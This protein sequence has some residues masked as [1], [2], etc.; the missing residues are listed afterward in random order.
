RRARSRHSSSTG[1]RGWSN[2]SPRRASPSP[3][4][5]T[6]PWTAASAAACGTP[7]PANGTAPSRAERARPTPPPVARPRGA[8]ARRRPPAAAAATRSSSRRRAAESASASSGSTQRWRR[9]SSPARSACERGC[10]QAIA[11]R[12]EHLQRERR[13]V[14]E[15][16]L[17]VL[18][19][20]EQEL[21]RRAR[22]HGSRSRCARNQANLT[23]KIAPLERTQVACSATH[24]DFAL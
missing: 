6:A 17:E 10:L 21:D 18:P 1:S 3:P 16:L 13:G 11:E 15:H 14:A 22:R 7:P 5:T 8:P 12:F 2:G 4:P 9:L 24:V 23:K 20:D 19:G